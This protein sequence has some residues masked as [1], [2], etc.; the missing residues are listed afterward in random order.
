MVCYYYINFVSGW[1]PTIILLI[2]H[3]G[4]VF[5][6]QVCMILASFRGMIEASMISVMNKHETATTAH[7]WYVWNVPNEINLILQKET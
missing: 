3:I 6:F 1:L 7:A 5:E 4:S 2:I